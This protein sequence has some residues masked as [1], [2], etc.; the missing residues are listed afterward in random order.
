MPIEATTYVTGGQVARWKVEEDQYSSDWRTITENGSVELLCLPSGQRFSVMLL[1]TCDES[2]CWGAD[3]PWG[4]GH[5]EFSTVD[6]GCY[7]S[8]NRRSVYPSTY[9]DQT[10]DISVSDS[11]CGRRLEQSELAPQPTTTAATSSDPDPD[12]ATDPATDP[13][14]VVNEPDTRGRPSPLIPSLEQ[15]IRR[16]LID[17]SWT[18]LNTTSAW[19]GLRGSAPHLLLGQL[20][21]RSFARDDMPPISSADEATAPG[22]PWRAGAAAA[23]LQRWRRL[24]QTLSD[25]DDR[26]SRYTSYGCSRHE[27]QTRPLDTD[28]SEWDPR[29]AYEAVGG[30]GNVF[31]EQG[32][33][34]LCAVHE[35]FHL[36]PKSHRFCRRRPSDASS[37]S[38][39]D[40]TGG[41]NGVVGDPTAL[42]VI[43]FSPLHFFYGPAS[44][45]IEA[46]SLDT[47]RLADFD[48]IATAIN[49]GAD[50]SSFAAAHVSAVEGVLDK[51]AAYK[52]SDGHW[53]HAESYEPQ[54][55]V[56]ACS[57][58]L[59]KNRTHVLHVVAQIRAHKSLAVHWTAIN[60]Y[61]DKD[62]S[63]SNLKSRFTRGHFV[64]GFPLADYS[65]AEQFCYSFD[66]DD[67][68]KNPE[69]DAQKAAYK[70]WFN[71]VLRGI[72]FHTLQ[73]T[74]FVLGFYDVLLQLVVPNLIR[75]VA[76]AV[77]VF[78]VVW[79]QT[80]AFIVA[81][82]TITE[83]FLSIASAVFFA[84]IVFQITWFTF[85]HMLVVYI[86]LAVGADDVF[87]FFDTYKQSFYAGT[88][89]NASLA[90][91]MSYVFR[92]AGLAMLIT[93]VSQSLPSPTLP[94]PD[95]DP[96]RVA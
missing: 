55:K 41:V 65:S 96:T 92:R 58:E 70:S 94:T 1:R 83:I 39:S 12:P 29:V 5:V 47:L 57:D 72:N 51:L 11:N 79:L 10:A 88:E 25:P 46:V 74:L 27:Q 69:F 23:R 52:G 64:A 20:V 31:S 61:F 38:S 84:A 85:E 24:Q 8:P 81:I 77:F 73:P 3:E 36:G 44:Y 14:R 13:S 56:F 18:L 43:R 34:E 50:T 93:S 60:Q 22:A 19:L 16:R 75:S 45:D 48:P 76:P 86:I 6:R 26:D 28:S 63:T 59:R 67:E 66:G 95:P 42:C 40:D 90:H 91:R 78:L 4:G 89:V 80:R 62:F 2:Y 32:L 68:I 15:V 71:G 54:N 49:T 37:D 35:A 17:S 82:A 7:W 30:D 33:K 21:E 9:D 87:V 53:Q